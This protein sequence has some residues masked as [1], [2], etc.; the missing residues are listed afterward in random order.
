MFRIGTIYLGPF[1]L[2]VSPPPF[3]LAEYKGY[4]APAVK[5][6]VLP[7]CKDYFDYT[8][9]FILLRVIVNYSSDGPAMVRLPGNPEFPFIDFRTPKSKDAIYEAEYRYWEA[10]KGQIDPVPLL[11]RSTVEKVIARCQE[12]C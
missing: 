4:L 12:L 5:E 3:D 10:V 6:M 9:E 7:F 2:R 8:R 11:H 1:E